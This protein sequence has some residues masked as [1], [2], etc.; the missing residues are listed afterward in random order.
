MEYFD[1]LRATLDD[2][3]PQWWAHRDPAS[4]AYKT[5]Q[6]LADLADE[7]AVD[8]EQIHADMALSTAG[9]AA[10]RSEWA[11]LYG[12][13]NEQLPPDTEILR[14]Y[15]QARAKDSGSREDLQ[16]ALIALTRNTD[17]DTGTVL[18]FADDGTGVTFPATGGLTLHEVVPD[19]ASLA[20]PI[21]GGGIPFAADGSGVPFPARGRVEVIE[22][23]TDS[24]V[25]VNV[26]E[27]LTFDR[28]QFARAVARARMAHHLPGVIAEV[29]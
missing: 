3:F 8:V 24:R 13:G 28:G 16:D 21:G 25:D 18:A 9:D 27:I 15:L 23:P 4:E 11:V 14:G 19:R 22:R 2:A 26:R 10:L 20:F 1:S 6:A 12:A 7:L 17:N 5:L 29:R